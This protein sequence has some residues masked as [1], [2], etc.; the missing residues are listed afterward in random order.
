MQL[1]KTQIIEFLEE[2]GQHQRADQA[3]QHLPEHEPITEENLEAA[4]SG[5]DISE[6]VSSH[7]ERPVVAKERVWS[8]PRRHRAGRGRGDSD[9]A[10]PQGAGLPRQHEHPEAVPL[11]AAGRGGQATQDHVDRFPEKVDRFPKK[12]DS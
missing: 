2:Q 6:A 12:E 10:G 9:R 5:P 1:D 3:Q 7:A 8:G 4:T 11:I